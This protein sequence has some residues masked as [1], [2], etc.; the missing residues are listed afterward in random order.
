MKRIR[1]NNILFIILASLAV[2]LA[3]FGHIVINAPSAK[4]MPDTPSYLEPGINLLEKG[5]FVNVTSAGAE[6]YDINRTPGYPIFLAILRRGL[7]WSFDGI[8][9]LQILITTLSGWIVYKAAREIDKSIAPLAAFIFLFDI[10][11]ILY[12]LILLTETLYTLFIALFALFFLR[13]LKKGKMGALVSAAAMAAIA[14]YIRPVSY[15]LGICVAGGVIYAAPRPLNIKKA[16]ARAIIFITVFYS[17]LAP[18]HY[19]NYIRSG[20]ADFTVIDNRDLR[21]MGITHK[22]ERDLR[23][24]KTDIKN[25]VLFYIDH[26]AKS[27]VQFFTLPGTFKYLKSNALKVLSKVFGYPWVA[28]WL[29]GLLFAGCRGPS[30]RFLLLTMLYFAAVSIAATGLCVGSRFRVPAMPFIA[31]LSACGWFKIA[32]KAKLFYIFRRKKR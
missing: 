1:Y 24:E 17:I 28:F 7:G 3:L 26:I 29:I 25:P 32:S 5:R 18:W 30:H 16:A 23:G 4:F 12:S 2:K 9:I 19:R 15:Y 20:N 6:Q 13:Y 8:V 22:Y 21:D 27:T 10:P 14:T 11:V 31:I